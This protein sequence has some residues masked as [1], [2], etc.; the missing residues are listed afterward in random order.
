M[1]KNFFPRQY[2]QIR[3]LWCRG[4]CHSLQQSK[5]NCCVNFIALAH[6]Y[7]FNPY[8]IKK[9]SLQVYQSY[10]TVVSVTETQYVLML[11]RGTQTAECLSKYKDR[12][13]V[14][15]Q[16]QVNLSQLV[17]VIRFFFNF[18]GKVKTSYCKEQKSSRSKNISVTA[19]YVDFQYN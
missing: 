5:K 16:L 9:N 4:S 18:W 19:Y 7:V 12:S 14:S 10:L 8:I 11:T 2:N 15:N 1:L 3:V 17:F 6:I 13:V